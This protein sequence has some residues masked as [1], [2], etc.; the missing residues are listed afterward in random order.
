MKLLTEDERPDLVELLT[1]LQEEAA[2]VSQAASK[3]IRFGLE[4]QNPGSPFTN[5]QELATELNDIVTV[6]Y[7]ITECA[8]LIDRADVMDQERIMAK[9]ERISTY[10]TY[11]KFQ[12][13]A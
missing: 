5:L 8:G 9:L 1:I 13:V 6:I 3:L 10:A 2:E 12:D 11:L 7:I 4:G